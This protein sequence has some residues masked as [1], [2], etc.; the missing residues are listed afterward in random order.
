MEKEKGPK[1]IAAD[2]RNGG[3]SLL[4][5]YVLYGRGAA[6]APESR[7][8]NVFANGGGGGGVQKDTSPAKFSTIFLTGG[9]KK[10]AQRFWLFTVC[11]RALHSYVRVPSSRIIY[12]H[13][14]RVCSGTL[15]SCP[16]TQ[17]RQMLLLLL[18]LLHLVVDVVVGRPLIKIRVVNENCTRTHT[19]GK[20]RAHNAPRQVGDDTITD[21]NTRR[22]RLG[23]RLGNERGGNQNAAATEEIDA[24]ERVRDQT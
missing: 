2:I 21:E 7:G 19:R 9:K 8:C 13:T 18:L 11:I 24:V 6:A 15:S 10:G 5:A 20:G 14:G 17:R 23:A 1:R 22:T 3:G 12:T 16:R 4:H